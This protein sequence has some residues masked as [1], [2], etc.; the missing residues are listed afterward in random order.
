MKITGLNTGMPM[1]RVM[2]FELTRE[3]FWIRIL[4]PNP[5]L[6]RFVACGW[7]LEEDDRGGDESGI[8]VGG[9]INAAIVLLR[10]PTETTSKCLAVGSLSTRLG[11]LNFRRVVG[12]STG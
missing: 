1:Y 10:N 7:R 9:I 3:R 4:Y 11:S 5:I 8:R 2:V 12:S 6:W